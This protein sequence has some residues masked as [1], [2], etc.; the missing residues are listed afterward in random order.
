ML[1][2]PLMAKMPMQPPPELATIQSSPVSTLG[3]NESPGET[4]PSRV[5]MPPEITQTWMSAP[6]SLAKEYA[7]A[8][9][10]DAEPL[11]L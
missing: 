9:P 2:P 11:E 6:L 8:E 1:P 7:T 3:L 5:P 4:V 10:P